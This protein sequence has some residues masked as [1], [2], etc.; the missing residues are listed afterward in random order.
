MLY[1]L[2]W[3]VI[4]VLLF[5]SAF[6][7]EAIGQ[8]SCLEQNIRT[9]KTENYSSE[10]FYFLR[11]SLLGKELSGYFISP[12]QARLKIHRGKVFFS[13]SFPRKKET[14]GLPYQ[15]NKVS[16][17]INGKNIFEEDFTK[18]C[19]TIG[20]SIFPGQKRY[21]ESFFLPKNIIQRCKNGCPLKLIVWGGL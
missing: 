18:N 7:A 12:L 2:Q 15:I 4:F 16:I 5:L 8:S 1:R 19:Q 11:S 21:L 6:V 17:V 10:S 9:V 3:M 13:A 20:W 14:V